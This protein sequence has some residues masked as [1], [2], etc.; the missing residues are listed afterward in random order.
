MAGIKAS[1][2]EKKRRRDE[3]SSSSDEEE[4]AVRAPQRKNESESDE[5]SDESDSSDDET[6]NTLFRPATVTKES[7]EEESSDEDE[8][9]EEEGE[10]DDSSSSE[11]E[12]VVEEKKKP[13]K[14]T[15]ATKAAVAKPSEVNTELEQEISRKT[16]ATVYIEGIPYKANE[17]DIV[18]HFSSCGI[19][20]EVRMP[21]YQDS[22]KPRGYAHVVFESASSIPK[23]LKLDRKDMMGRYL[24]V[25]QAERP[26]SLE[27][28]L[29]E[30][31]SVKKAVKGCRT[32]F[33]KH[34]P[35]DVE[36]STIK[37]ALSTCGT[38]QSVRLPLWNHT[39]KLKGF[40]YVEFSTED[41]AVAAVKRSGMKIGD[42]MVIISLET[43]TSAPKASFRLSDGRFWNK[44]EEAKSSLAKKLT[45]KS[46][47]KPSAHSNKKHKTK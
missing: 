2:T 45:E 17:G 31:K 12:E 44:G 8:D 29:R 34:L 9:E 18:T 5:S 19:V 33:I 14:K 27:V 35:Y 30:Q 3:S 23:A 10:E 32:V 16:E 22:G 20:K 38:V 1:K 36:E 6:E 39:K 4:H 43:A 40:G 37:E 13:A 25:K 47:A 42:R 46:K 11:E 41:E 21:R 28:A 24:T 7:E 26:R 15:A